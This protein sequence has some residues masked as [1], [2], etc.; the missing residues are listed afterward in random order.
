MHVDGNVK[1][2]L[3]TLIKDFRGIG[4]T[5]SRLNLGNLYASGLSY[6]QLEISIFFV[7]KFIECSRVFSSIFP[8][9]VETIIIFKEKIIWFHSIQKS[10]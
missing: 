8:N 1:S 7:S 2:I 10:E 6:T 4:I 5:V 3:K 9:T